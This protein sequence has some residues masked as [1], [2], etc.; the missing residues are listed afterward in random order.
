MGLGCKRKIFVLKYLFGVFCERRSGNMLDAIQ[1]VNYIA[2]LLASI[3]AFLVGWLWY[4]KI[5]FADVWMREMNFSPED[6]GNPNV[7]MI[8]SGVMIL[9][10]SLGIGILIQWLDLSSLFSV[11][12]L[13]FSIWFL[14]SLPV[15]LNGVFF[16]GKSKTLFFI[17]TGHKL[18]EILTISLIIGLWK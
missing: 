15:E 5:M 12:A 9:L 7:S 8:G 14:G 18:A 10:I 1:E 3:I 11:L 4:S 13:G 16:G 6:L 2:V 17:H